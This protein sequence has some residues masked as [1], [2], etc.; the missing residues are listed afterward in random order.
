MADYE[1]EI[2]SLIPE[3][4]LNYMTECGDHTADK[5]GGLWEKNAKKN[6]DKFLNK[7]GTVGVEFRGFAE[8]KAVIIVG[9]GPS[10]KKNKDV[11]KKLYEFN[12]GFDIEEQPFVI[13]ASN[14]MLKP[15]LDMGIFPHFT[16]VLDSGN[17]FRDQFLNLNTDLKCV[18]LAN[19]TADHKMLKRWDRDGH[20]ISFFMS[21]SDASRYK[22]EEQA[23]HMTTYVGGNVM[24]TAFMLSLRF[25]HSRFIITLGNDLSFPLAP[26]HEERKRGFYSDGNYDTQEGKKD[27]AKNEVAWMAYGHGGQGSFDKDSQLINYE[28][29]LTS[30]QLLTY[31][32]WIEFHV[33]KWAEEEEFSFRY[34]N[35]SEGGICGVVAKKHEVEDLENPA[36]WGLMDD[37][38]PKCWFTKPLI[39]AAKDFLEIKKSCQTQMETNTNVGGVIEL[40][41]KMGGVR[42]IDLAGQSRIISV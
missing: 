36:N 28:K 16:I 13:I 18:M 17:H 19:I 7:H 30:K 32:T 12:V 4:F 40:P 24:N 25:L 38:A 33:A 31:K 37:V 20:R 6:I 42:G 29:V 14:H 3:V 22:I 35:C 1:K 41:P 26:D 11:L 5:L 34:Y 9:A 15:L 8:N 27:E 10:F 2:N 23:E 39:D 21:E